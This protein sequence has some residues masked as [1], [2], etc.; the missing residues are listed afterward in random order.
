MAKAA[1]ILVV[2]WLIFTWPFWVKGLI[3]APLD[4]LVGFFA[5]WQGDYSMP[6][7]NP[8]IPDVV[9][10]II[11]WKIFTM[12]EWQQGRVPLWNPYNFSG[13]PHAAN[14]QSAVFYPL[15]LIFML[16]RFDTAWSLYIL[17]QPLLAGLFTYAYIRSLKLSRPA[18]LLAS[19]AFMWSGFITTWLE[20][21]TLGHA[22]L[23]LSAVLWAVEKSKIKTVILFL[24]LSLLAGHLQTSLYVIILTSAYFYFT[25]KRRPFAQ[26]RGRLVKTLTIL[27]MPFFLTA[28]QFFPSLELYFNSFRS[29]EN[30]VD[31]FQAFRIPIYSLVTWFAPDWFGHPVTRNSFGDHSYVE[32]TGYIGLIP[33]LLALLTVGIKSKSF[34][35]KFFWWTI[36]ISLALSLK[37]PLANLLVWLHVPILA[38]SSPARIIALISFSLSILVGFGFDYLPNLKK[39]T[40]KKFLIG[41]SLIFASFWLATVV[42]HL[43]VSQRNLILPTVIFILFTLLMLFR[44]KLLFAT[45]YLL[46]AVTA[47]D[48]FRFHH[49]FTPYTDKKLWY[50]QMKFITF[51]QQNQG[52]NRSFGIFDGQLNLPFKIYSAEGYDTLFPK[53]YGQLL[54]LNT[55]GRVSSAI[56][57]K[58]SPQTMSLLNLLGVKYVVQGV[59][60]GAAPWELQ[61]WNYPDQFINVYEDERYQVFRNNKAQ[62]RAYLI[63]GGQ[64]EITT[65]TPQKIVIEVDSAQNNTL[66]LSDNYYSGWRA[67]V[68]DQATRI[69]RTDAALRSVD[70]PAGQHTVAMT[71]QSLSFTLGLAISI[72]SLIGLALL[73]MTST[74][75]L[76]YDVYSRHRRMAALITAKGVVLDVGGSLRELKQFVI[77]PITTVDVIGGDVIAAGTYLPF[78]NNSFD[79]VVSLDTIEHIPAKNRLQ[80]ISESLR[81]A[82]KQVIIA[83]PMGTA[84]HQQAE[85]Q[86]LAAYP[87][88]RYLQEHIQY[89]LPTLVDIKTWV[90]DLP[91]HELSFSDDW[92]LA[93]LMFKF[94]RFEVSQPQFNRLI[95]YGKPLIN[96]L[97]NTLIFPFTK[98]VA[99]TQTVNRWFLKFRL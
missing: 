90:K 14:W 7:K 96:W 50:P 87:K 39:S 25:F 32:M 59:V 20:W 79:I 76:P 80:F 30:A 47:G 17:L 28:F 15:N 78:K 29:Q 55:S 86:L 95:Y 43:P 71:Y 92:R 84:A 64:A 81:V 57:P 62:S 56:I 75:F 26:A 44:P 16:L 65:Y 37:T 61:L 82:K 49:K 40:L 31:W 33:L 42:F 8:A 41:I 11:P 77:N 69:N 51:L 53:T 34:H 1:A 3:P 74:K 91:A 89:D 63:N 19:M 36:I 66:I 70:V 73:K 9:N 23:W 13:T 24:S 18:A 46:F 93:T 21:G 45:S 38:A 22:L 2:I 68:D 58:N 52:V 12:G 99:Y 48:L 72:I 83:A 27:V 97:A 4:F 60:H 6:I 67:M 85:A 35:V 5:P 88:D 10:Q 98:D 94:H 54:Q